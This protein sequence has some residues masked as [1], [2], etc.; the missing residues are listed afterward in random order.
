MALEFVKEI[1]KILGNKNYSLNSGN[2]NSNPNQ[3]SHLHSHPNQSNYNQYSPVSEVDSSL[4]NFGYGNLLKQ[5]EEV[6]NENS[7]SNSPRM[8]ENKIRVNSIKNKV[9]L[10]SPNPPQGVRGHRYS[11]SYALNDM[12]EIMKHLNIPMHSNQNEDTV[13]IMTATDGHKN[14]SKF[15]KNQ[16]SLPEFREKASIESPVKLTMEESK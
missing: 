11:P 9:E 10:T 14:L 16:N 1:I 15:S 12:S 5:I 7:V 2:N 3:N 4:F 8:I 6:D 13:I